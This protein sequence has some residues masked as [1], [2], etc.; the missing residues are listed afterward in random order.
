M[1]LQGAQ[2]GLSGL[3]GHIKAGSVTNIIFDLDGTLIDSSQGVLSTL[4]SVLI[5][6]NI[7]PVCKLDSSLIGPP[8]DEL[9]KTVTGL[10]DTDLIRELS[11]QFIDYYDQKGY[12]QTVYFNGID[13]ALIK[14]K[15]R[16]HRVFIA[17]NKRTIPT[18][19]I[20][21]LFGWEMF[22]EGVYSL[23]QCPSYN[24]KADLLSYIVDRHRLHKSSTIYI[25]DT[26]S[27]RIAAYKEKL[28]YLMVGWG[29][30]DVTSAD[31]I[32]TPKQLTD[33]IP[34]IVN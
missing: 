8:L 7:S 12:A 24:N 20:I 26:E 22:F 34:A 17:T 30:G 18:Q 32:L 3:L 13:D 2:T 1:R 33:Y 23:D 6:N 31:V 10:G 21:S 14:L 19:K 28:G 5:T 4:R 16:R 15:N 27:D 9:I 29:Y 25:G 11:R